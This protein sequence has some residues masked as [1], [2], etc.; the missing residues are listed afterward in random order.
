MGSAAGI[1]ANAGEGC[2]A[3]VI[4]GGLIEAEGAAPIG[5]TTA[6]GRPEIRITGGAFADEWAYLTTANG[7]GYVY[8]CEI[9]VSDD[10]RAVVKNLDED[11]ADR[12]PVRVVP[13]VSPAIAATGG[14]YAYD[15]EPLPDDE[16][17]VLPAPSGAVSFSFAPAGG[18]L[19]ADGL[20]TD[21]G[22]WEVR[23]H[24]EPF[25]DGSAYYLGETLPVTVTIEP[26]AFAFEVADQTLAPG[27]GVGDVEVPDGAEGVAGEQVAGTVA[28][29]LDEAH[30]QPVPVD[31]ALEGEPGSAQ[32]LYWSF[33][34]AEG[35][36]NYV[37][38]A[39]SG[40]VTLTVGEPAPEEPELGDLEDPSGG[41]GS[42]EGSESDDGSDDARPVPAGD[43]IPA[44]GDPTS[45]L[46]AVALALGVTAL[47]AGR[48]LRAREG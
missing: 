38:E 19:E 43:A 37:D 40:S 42:G 12:Y 18:G 8:E 17:S 36:S 9:G 32:V 4:E 31:W 28:W 48:A 25:S 44:T 22:T 39:L 30:E 35:Q 13:V 14:T 5:H 6:A 15:G 11:T 20:P 3:I 7:I 1:G 33:T 26:A 27:S 47:A 29:Y 34:P 21:A 2:G 16:F 45:G 46:P 10:G 41:G 23:A 24:L